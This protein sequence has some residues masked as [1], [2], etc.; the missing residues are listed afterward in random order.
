M[1]QNIVSLYD[2]HDKAVEAVK[3]LKSAGFKE[4]HSIYWAKRM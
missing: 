2:H 1:S 3:L 4:K